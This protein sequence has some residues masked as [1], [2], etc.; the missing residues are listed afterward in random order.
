M[1][2]STYLCVCPTKAVPDSHAKRTELHNHHVN[3]IHKEI[4]KNCTRLIWLFVAVWDHTRKSEWTKNAAENA[5]YLRHDMMIGN[6]VPASEQVTSVRIQAWDLETILGALS[7]RSVKQYVSCQL[8]ERQMIP[9]LSVL[10]QKFPAHDANSLQILL[11]QKIAEPNHFMKQFS[12]VFVRATC[13][14]DAAVQTIRSV[15]NILNHLDKKTPITA[16]VHQLLMS[17]LRAARHTISAAIT[18]TK[19]S[20]HNKASVERVF[21]HKKFRAKKFVAQDVDAKGAHKGGIALNS[22]TYGEKDYQG[23]LQYVSEQV[24]GGNNRRAHL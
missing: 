17:L 24:D 11:D 20:T 12:K 10:K 22:D 6:G 18:V 1:P 3:D 13:N 16:E 21:A 19:N 14:T 23:Y 2:K 5:K 15:R 9:A 4:E 8:R 7:V